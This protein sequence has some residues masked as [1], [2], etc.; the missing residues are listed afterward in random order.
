MKAKRKAHR[1]LRIELIYQQ[2]SL[3]SEATSELGDAD[4]NC[5][6]INIK[7]QNNDTKR[8]KK[9]K[10]KPFMMDNN[11]CIS[12]NTESNSRTN[13]NKCNVLEENTEEDQVSDD[14]DTVAED[15]TKVTIT[16]PAC[17]TVQKERK[18]KDT[19]S[20]RN[21]KNKIE[22]GRLE[23]TLSQVNGKDDEERQSEKRVLITKDDKEK[24]ENMS[25]KVKLETELVSSQINKEDSE[26]NDMEV[27]VT[28]KTHGKRRKM[29][30]T[31][32]TE[33][34]MKEVT[35]ET[36]V[37][38]PQIN[39]M[40]YN[41]EVNEAKNIQ[42]FT[43]EKEETSNCDFNKLNNASCLQEE[44]Q[45]N[46]LMTNYDGYWVLRE[47]MESLE[48]AKKMELEAIFAARTD[49]SDI[50]E[51]KLTPKEQIVLQRAM[52]KRKRFQHRKLLQ[53]LSKTGRKVNDAG[54]GNRGGKREDDS[55]KVVQFDGFW[56]KKDAAD[57]LHKLRSEYCFNVLCFNV[58]HK[59]FCSL[60][61]K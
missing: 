33:E 40:E 25:K 48:A 60:V 8:T 36:E 42:L 57:R 55:G 32:E 11:L 52:K 2:K 53:N 15:D 34:K 37:A 13:A 17:D 12:P 9:K 31:Q 45:E 35:Q 51:G 38:E 6:G 24:D 18:T 19:D 44:F 47:E 54:R 28:P 23:A 61:R 46:E 14:N 43:N 29:K 27:T 4:S 39:M 16:P 41:N 26:G 10:Q 22:A 20:K 21:K 3:V 49:E 5:R 56:V 58:I 1:E 59:L 50:N 7:K 30:A